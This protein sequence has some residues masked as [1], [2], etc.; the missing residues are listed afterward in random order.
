MS[1]FKIEAALIQAYQ[2]AGL[3]LPTEYENAEFARPDGN[4]S[5]ASVLFSPNQ[6]GVSSLGGSGADEI[7]GYL[8]VDIYTERNKGTAE[9]RN[10]SDL[11]RTH[12][13]AGTRFAYD[14]QDVLIRSCGRNQ[15][16]VIDGYFM[17]SITI[18]WRAYINRSL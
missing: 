17:I 9:A 7:D 11:L 16:R 8:Q 14:G 1:L 2:G 6:P 15:G 10:Y 18:F 13:Q 12:F 5:Y 3:L 4:Q